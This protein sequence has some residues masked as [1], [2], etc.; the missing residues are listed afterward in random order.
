MSYLIV[1]SP[2]GQLRVTANEQ[3]ITHIEFPQRWSDALF[4]GPY[5]QTPLLMAAAKQLAAYFAGEI[6]RFELPLAPKGTEFQ[7]RCWAQL[8]GLPFGK[9][10]SYGEIAKAIGQEKAVRAVGAA[11]GRNPIPI[12]IPCHRVI[13]SNGSLT[14]FGGGIETKRWLLEHEASHRAKFAHASSAQE[15]ILA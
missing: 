13:G 11:N 14:G 5:E 4:T 12:V 7:R 9:V 2:I 10:S 6:D 3:A 15:P 8:Q 1:E